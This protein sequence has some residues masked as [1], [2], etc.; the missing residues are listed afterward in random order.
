MLLPRD[1]ERAIRLPDRDLCLLHF[2]CPRAF[3]HQA[4]LRLR[5]VEDCGCDLNSLLR[6]R[7]P[8]FRLLDTLIGLQPLLV[9]RTLPDDTELLL[10]LSEGGFRR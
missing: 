5:G 2:L 7:F 4:E 6:L 8:G 9:A 10:Y 3:F 1:A